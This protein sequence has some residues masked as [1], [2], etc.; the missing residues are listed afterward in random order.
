MRVHA[1]PEAIRA[2]LNLCASTANEIE[3]RLGQV[4]GKW[5]AAL[6]PSW[7]D[8]QATMFESG[9]YAEAERIRAAL[10]LLSEAC[11]RVEVALPALEAYIGGSLSAGTTA[12]DVPRSAA[13]H[14]EPPRSADEKHVGLTQ[15]T[16]KGRNGPLHLWAFG[17]CTPDDFQWSDD[18]PQRFDEDV[19]HSY[20]SDDYRRWARLAPEV[21]ERIRTDGDAG[22][23][24]DRAAE[25]V[26]DVFLGSEPVRIIV[27]P[28]QKP[29]VDGGRHRIMAAIET[30]VTIPVQIVRGRAR[31]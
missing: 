22:L 17:E 26:R 15:E 18:F 24:G 30:G 1:D 4:V 31:R 7:R 23:Q 6:E 9:L 5:G 8:R 3:T 2:L 12:V 27:R 28:G 19:H 11:R 20:T 29:E 21:V 10:G 16:I 14:A 25:Q 13:S